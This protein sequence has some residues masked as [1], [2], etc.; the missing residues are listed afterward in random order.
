MR[1]IAY[2][3]DRLSRWWLGKTV[4]S[5][6]EMVGCDGVAAYASSVDVNSLCS[7]LTAVAA[8]ASNFGVIS[9]CSPL[10]AVAAYDSNL[11]VDSQCSLP[12]LLKFRR[13]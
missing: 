4:D 7:F 8:Y 2:H 1:R 5:V 13:H 6:V 9:L 10:T 11:A 12:Q 3:K